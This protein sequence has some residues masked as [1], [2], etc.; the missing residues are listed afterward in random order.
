MPL[1][2]MTAKETHDRKVIQY[3]KLCPSE[4]LFRKG[5]KTQRG[6]LLLDMDLIVLED[7]SLPH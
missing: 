4:A 3:K 1:S 7:A 6:R 5:D 2:P